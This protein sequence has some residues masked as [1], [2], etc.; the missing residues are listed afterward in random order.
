MNRG[1]KRA[2]ANIP[3]DEIRAAI[4]ALGCLKSGQKYGVS[5]M[6]MSMEARRRGIVLR[7]GRP[8]TKPKLIVAANLVEPARVKMAAPPPMPSSKL[9]PKLT[10]AIDRRMNRLLEIPKREIADRLRFVRVEDLA[11]ELKCT[12]SDLMH[13]LKYHRLDP[14][15]K[16]GPLPDHTV[17]RPELDQSYPLFIDQ[18]VDHDDAVARIEHAIRWAVRWGCM[19]VNAAGELVREMD[20]IRLGRPAEW[21]PS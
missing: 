15:P 7:Q 8:S 17:W 5:A 9:P 10:E 2:L 13:V 4:M 11:V 1:P 6:T 14:D 21:R 3:D 18:G 16:P 12:V 19:H 20:P